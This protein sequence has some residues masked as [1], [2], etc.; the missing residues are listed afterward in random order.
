MQ[1]EMDRAN[2]A[3]VIQGGRISKEI[4]Q[5]AIRKVLRENSRFN[6]RNTLGAQRIY[7][8]KQSLSKLAGKGH[9]LSSIEITEKNI[10]SFEKV[11]RKYAVSYALKKDKSCDPARYIVFFKAKDYAQMK[12]AFTEY[13][14][15][16]LGKSKKPTL[17]EKLADINKEKMLESKDKSIEKVM[18]KSTSK[19]NCLNP[20]MK[21]AEVIEGR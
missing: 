15:K 9:E 13:A 5:A 16:S 19:T 7:S 4:L 12:T 18:Q 10:K 3:I 17:L 20:A 8:G 6:S 11:A 21:T 1:E 14:G 2:M